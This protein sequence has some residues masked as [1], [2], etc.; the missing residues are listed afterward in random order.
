M[1]LRSRVTLSHNLSMYTLICLQR[2]FFMFTIMP[3]CYSLLHAP[4]VPLPRSPHIPVYLFP[5]LCVHQSEVSFYIYIFVE[6]GG[7][8]VSSVP[9]VRRCGRNKICKS[10]SVPTE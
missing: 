7:S 10:L 2:N 5:P 4:S 3:C 6:R 1:L 8:V 9:C